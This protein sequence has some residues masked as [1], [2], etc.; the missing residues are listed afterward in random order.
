MVPSRPAAPN[1]FIGTRPSVFSPTSM[2][3]RSFSMATTLPLTTVPSTG[4]MSWKLSMRSCSK[5]SADAVWLAIKTPFRP[6]A[7]YFAVG[8]DDKWLGRGRDHIGGGDCR[9]RCPLIRPLRGHL[10]PR[11][12]KEK[13][14]SGGVLS[15]S[16]LWGEG[17][18]EGTSHT[19]ISIGPGPAEAYRLKAASLD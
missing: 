19:H 14:G 13:W 6:E 3:A 9:K 12:A 18:G 11:G 1:S 5:S 4:S 15:P 7:E 2:M 10:L 16:P 8:V 17:R